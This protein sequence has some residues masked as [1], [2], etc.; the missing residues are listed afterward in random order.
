MLERREHRWIVLA[1]RVERDDHTRSELGGFLQSTADGSRLALILTHPDK[2]V[3]LRLKRNPMM[4]ALGT[5]VGASVV[6]HD[7][8]KARARNAFKHLAHGACMVVKRYD[9]DRSRHT[10]RL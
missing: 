8:T 9:D 6:D 4:D 1:I 10:R 7:H 3:P 5:I 2:R